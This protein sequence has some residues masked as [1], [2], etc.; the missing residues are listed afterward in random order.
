M[1]PRMSTKKTSGVLSILVLGLT[2]S[3]GN[4]GNPEISDDGRTG[5]IEQALCTVP[6]STPWPVTWV[7]GPYLGITSGTYDYGKGPCDG[8]VVGYY[9]GTESM[10]TSVTV[11]LE[12]NLPASKCAATTLRVSLWEVWAG[13]PAYDP[14]AYVGT[15][16]AQP[17]MVGS[18]CKGSVNILSNSTDPRVRRSVIKAQAVTT[19]TGGGFTTYQNLPVVV[20]IYPRE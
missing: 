1:L 2:T 3:C 16:E 20:R 7:P 13:H 17:S 8:Y 18:V 6:T 12:A 14:Y 10:G 19:T 15:T 9:P 4:P 5:T 11:F